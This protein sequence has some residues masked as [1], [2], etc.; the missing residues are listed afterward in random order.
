MVQ[1]SS[2]MQTINTLTISRTYTGSK[3]IIM[4]KPISANYNA[5]LL[6]IIHIPHT[7]LDVNQPYTA[8]TVLGYA[9]Q[10]VISRTQVQRLCPNPFQPTTVL[11]LYLKAASH[12]AGLSCKG[13]HV[14]MV[15]SPSISNQTHT[16]TV[17]GN[18]RRIPACNQPY[19]GSKTMSKPVSA[20]HSAS[21]ILKSSKPQR[22]TVMQGGTCT[23]GSIT[24]YIK[25]NTHTH[26]TRKLQ[27]YTSM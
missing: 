4:S 22:R 8:H 15:Q 12:N 23:Y 11:V 26:S 18:Y 6:P 27:A 3:T 9:Y 10:H 17:P 2:T 21:T 19:T 13:G 25:S 7:S 14:P 20:N 5:S 1:S 16:H 24:L